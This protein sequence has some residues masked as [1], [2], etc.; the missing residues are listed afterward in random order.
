[1][2]KSF[3]FDR[4]NEADLLLFQK[5]I[6][7]GREHLRTLLSSTEIEEL[8]S[9]DLLRSGQEKE[10]KASP[11]ELAGTLTLPFN[12]ILTATLGAWIGLSGF[13]GV[14]LTSK[15][16][17]QMVMVLSVGIGAVVGIWNYRFTKKEIRKRIEER[18]LQNIQL[19]ILDSLNRKRVQEIKEKI[20]ELNS[21][22]QTIQVTSDNQAEVILSSEFNNHH[23]CLQWLQ[24]LEHLIEERR[25]KGDSEIYA[26]FKDEIDSIKGQIAK[27]LGFQESEKQ[28]MLPSLK[29][30]IQAAL[31]LFKKKRSWIQANWKSLLV[32]VLPTLFGMFSSIFVYLNDMPKI[33]HEVGWEEMRYLL[34]DPKIKAIELTLAILT[35]LYFA[36]S[37]VNSN[38]KRFHRD[39]ELAGAQEAIIKKQGSLSMLNDK[40][41]KIKEALIA[42]QRISGVFNVLK[43]FATLRTR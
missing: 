26:L 40:L 21:L 15:L 23:A 29:K 12:S 8:C 18:Q 33:T 16:L 25:E 10:I 2:L 37:F 11:T 9:L 42:I 24:K 7:L 3:L 19:Y 4:L 14:L 28:P 22:L 39:Q 5:H 17:F 1:M 30:L 36:F 43:K 6:E 20:D 35:T 38:R 34:M 32:S 13:M 41:L 31:P 27:S